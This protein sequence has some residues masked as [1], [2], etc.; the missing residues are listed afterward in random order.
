VAFSVAAHATWPLAW[1][2]VSEISRIMIQYVGQAISS[3]P[4]LALKSLFA[5]PG[6]RGQNRD[7]D[8]I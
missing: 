7:G 4:M 8:P 5:L 3:L 2:G 6:T 1:I